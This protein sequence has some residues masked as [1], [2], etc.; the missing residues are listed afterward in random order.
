M[1]QWKTATSDAETFENHRASAISP[2]TMDQIQAHQARHWPTILSERSTFTQ[3]NLRG[4]GFA[5][6]HKEEVALV[7]LG[8]K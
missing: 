7:R 4:Q 1:G 2:E 5:L 6:H 3:L 8:Y